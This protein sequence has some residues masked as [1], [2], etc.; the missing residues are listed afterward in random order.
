[1]SSS[2]SRSVALTILAGTLGFGTAANAE[3][4]LTYKIF[5]APGAGTT[6]GLGQGTLGINVN[7]FGVILG[8]IRDENSVRHGYLRFPDEKF[9]V[10]DHPSTRA[11]A[12]MARTT[13][14]PALLALT[15]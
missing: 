4:P 14:E 7:D 5:D 1:M 10:F 6:P 13:R 12:P 15:R 11:P 2:T 8:L 3:P 9:L